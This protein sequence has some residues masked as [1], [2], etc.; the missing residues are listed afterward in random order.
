MDLRRVRAWDWLAGFA[1]AVLIGSL[2]LD[3]YRLPG[4]E[5]VNAWD[6]FTVIDVILFVVGLVGIALVVAN[7]TQRTMAIPQALSTLSFIPALVAAVLTVYRT[8]SPPGDG[9]TRQVGVWLALGASLAL[10]VAATRAMSDERAPRATMPR[11][12]RI[13]TP[14]AK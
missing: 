13:P 14:E 1:G 3:W 9:E 11:V 4:G 10:L 8:A 7:A 6:A 12:E 2:F 5:S